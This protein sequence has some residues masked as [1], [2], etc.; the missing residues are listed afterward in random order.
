MRDLE[1]RLLEE[2]LEGLMMADGLDAA[3]IGVVE[4]CG[5]PPIL[6]YDVE[7]AVAVLV[8][9]DGMTDDEALEFLEFNSIGAWVGPG[10][11]GWLTIRLGD[12]A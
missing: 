7:K 9:R 11:P 5:Q 8:E 6:V 10:T 3:A 2:G 1:D 4:R 12:G